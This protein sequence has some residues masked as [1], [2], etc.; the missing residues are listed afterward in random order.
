MWWETWLLFMGD[1]GAAKIKQPSLFPTTKKQNISSAFL[2]SSATERQVKEKG[3]GLD[4]TMQQM[5]QLY[6]TTF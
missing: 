3:Y 2:P 6:H 4:D 5:N 1:L